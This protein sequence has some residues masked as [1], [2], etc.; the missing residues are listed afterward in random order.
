[1]GY[2]ESEL[3]AHWCVGGMTYQFAVASDSSGLDTAA[4]AKITITV[5]TPKPSDGILQIKEEQGLEL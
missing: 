1:M 5:V 4:N 2:G 3:V